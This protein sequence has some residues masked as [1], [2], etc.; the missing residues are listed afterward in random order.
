MLKATF[1]MEDMYNFNAG[2]FDIATQTPDDINGRFQTLG[3]AQQFITYGSF[4]IT[5]EW[6]I[7]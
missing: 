6:T 7:K 1:T 5:H 4:T 3:W 2:M